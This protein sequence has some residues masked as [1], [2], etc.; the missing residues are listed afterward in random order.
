MGIRE[1][2]LLVFLSVLLIGCGATPGEGD[3]NIPTVIIEPQ[4]EALEKAKA[5][6]QTV[7][8]AGAKQKSELEKLGI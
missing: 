3:D 8:D 7:L 5:V 4:L 1:S 6:E 2:F